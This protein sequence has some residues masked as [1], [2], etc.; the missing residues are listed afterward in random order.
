MSI[1]DRFLAPALVIVDMQNDFVRVGAPLEVPATRDTL[2]QHRRLIDAFRRRALPVVYLRWISVPQ[3]P[4]LQLLPHFSWVGNLDENIAACRPGRMRY[5]SELGAES[6]A[7]A[8]IDELAPCDGDL[9]IDKRGYG[10]FLGTELHERLQALGVQSLIV[11]GVVAEICVEDTVRQAFQFH[12][13][14]TV[15]SD[16]VASRR[17]DRQAAMLERIA[18]GYGWVSTSDEVVDALAH[19]RWPER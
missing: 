7:A 16:A 4:Y 9:Q 3:D 18:A 5:Y 12:Y 2:E 19:A 14:T 17:P 15:V 10:G 11:T 13:R 8:V 6:D 1:L